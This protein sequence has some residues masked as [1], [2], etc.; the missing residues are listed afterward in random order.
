MDGW[1]ERNQKK[2]LVQNL[3]AKSIPPKSEKPQSVFG[4][5]FLELISQLLIHSKYILNFPACCK[6]VM[7][8]SENNFQ[9]VNIVLHL[10]LFLSI[11]TNNQDAL[12]SLIKT[13]PLTEHIQQ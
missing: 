7:K 3:D 5:V 11:S 4:E 13:R 6:K 1:I 8:E 9:R 2:N 12:R 10:L